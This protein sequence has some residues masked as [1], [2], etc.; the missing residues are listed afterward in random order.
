MSATEKQ[1]RGR[2]VIVKR[3]REAF[4]L[5]ELVVVLG[6]VA[7]VLGVI[8]AGASA[9]WSN[10]KI[11]RATRQIMDVVNNVRAYYGPND[12]FAALAVGDIT[13]AVDGN[14]LI[15]V[16]MRVMPNVTGGAINHAIASVFPP[17]AVGSF[18]LWKVAG[19]NDRVRMQLL[20]LVRE[21]CAKLLT[22]FPVLMPEIGVLRIGTTVNNTPV[23]AY[24][25]VNGGAAAG[26]L[27]LSAAMAT[28]WCNLAGPNNV[29]EID[30][31]LRN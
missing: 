4:T 3:R 24:D 26:V 27:P 25:V 13:A 30:F 15:P 28:A 8:W 12:A 19:G 6:I 7:I 18:H 10:Y 17:T 20:G 31:L 1:T 2:G 29:V 5:I 23:N 22:M 9:V 21:D 11:E 14:G 16:E